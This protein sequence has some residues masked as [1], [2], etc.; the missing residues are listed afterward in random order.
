MKLLIYAAAVLAFGAMGCVIFCVVVGGVPALPMLGALLPALWNTLH[1]IVLTLLLA[2][3]VGIGAAVY[4]VEYAKQD[5]LFVKL[6]R[7]AAQSLAG[8]PSIVWGLFGYLLFVLVCRLGY[9]M[10]AG[11]LTLSLMVLPV[12]QCSTE[13]ALL[14]VPQSLREA[15]R[16]LGIC[17][18]QTVFRIV[19]PNAANG[20]LSGVILS[21]G[22]IVGETAALL[23]TAGTLGGTARSLMASGRTLAVELYC[24][25]NE[26]FYLQ[27]AYGAAV[28]LLLLV[29]AIN[30]AASKLAKRV[31]DG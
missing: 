22:R 5:S 20:I 14:A 4:L 7:K 29:G 13:E 30:A 16:A 18:R 19:L 1:M 10:L 12:L 9:S 15:S 24:I 6:S 25:L 26:G 31:G 3:P 11:A 8:L 23:C 2:L 27:E 17:K 28:L 21:I